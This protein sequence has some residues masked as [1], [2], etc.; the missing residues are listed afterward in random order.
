MS[1]WT[2]VRSASRESWHDAFKEV[3]AIALISMM[4]LLLKALYYYIEA[5]SLPAY[6]SFLKV[7][8]YRVATGDLM[9]FSIS[10]FAAIL[11]LASKDY[12]DSFEERIWFIII[13][14]VGL[15]ICT[16]FVG[17]NPDFKI[18]PIW[19]VQPFSLVLFIISLSC[20]VQLL[21]FQHYNSGDF[22]NL[23]QQEDKNAA[24]RLKRRRGAK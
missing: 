17:L 15:G 16:F 22:N 12:E 10:N 14:A 11:W 9:L 2:A 4:P 5:T 8:A 6:P 7:F 18:A 20:N 3:G 24:A 19:I 21:M 1:W 13:S 23:Q